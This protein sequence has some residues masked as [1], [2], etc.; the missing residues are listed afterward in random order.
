MPTLPVT[1]KNGVATFSGL[2][3]S[4][5][6]AGYRLMAS[7]D[8]LTTTLIGP[9]TVVNPPTISAE[10]VLFAGKGKHRHVVGFEL[11]FSEALD[12]T[13]ARMPPTTP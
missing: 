2:T 5:L 1:A 7:T 9:V 12:P 8:P 10:K 3:L 13:R 4:Q 6:G 11:D